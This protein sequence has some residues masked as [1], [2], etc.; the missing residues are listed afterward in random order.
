MRVSLQNGGVWRDK[1]GVSAIEFA[2]V[3]PILLMYVGAVETGNLLTVTRRVETVASTA[4][5]LTAQVKEVSNSRP[6]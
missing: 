3:A 1:R 6:E 4:G 5:D 2:P